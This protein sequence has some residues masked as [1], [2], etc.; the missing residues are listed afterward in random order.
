MAEFHPTFKKEG[1][2]D[3]AR[4]IGLTRRRR[5]FHE[6]GTV[7]SARGTR[8]AQ[9]DGRRQKKNTALV[10]DTIN[11]RLTGMP[12]LCPAEI[13]VHTVDNIPACLV[14]CCFHFATNQVTSSCQKKRLYSNQ[15][16]K[17]LE[18]LLWCSGNESD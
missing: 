7:F 11:G 2:P 13:C 17:V 1:T 14:F 10:P 12:L 9:P 16:Y 3:H 5:Q 15:K 8:R 6:E 18:F 4:S